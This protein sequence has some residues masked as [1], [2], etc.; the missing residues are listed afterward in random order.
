MF[1]ALPKFMGLLAWQSNASL[2]PTKVWAEQT[3]LNGRQ[4]VRYVLQEG[5]TVMD[6]ETMAEC[7]ADGV[8]MGEIM[9]KGN[10]V[11][12]GYLK[13]P[14]ATQEAFAGGWFHTGDLASDGTR[15]LRE[16]QRIAAKTSSS[17]AVKTS[18]L[19]K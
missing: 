18:A 4:G 7:P 8:T 15:P 6:P 14:K 1:M 2:G 10:I 12:K 16:N 11:M 19:S 3:R 5:M 9:F 13:N 17:Q